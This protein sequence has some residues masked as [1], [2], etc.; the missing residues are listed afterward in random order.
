MY[1]SAVWYRG[2]VF[3]YFHD[4]L[5]K[6]FYVMKH[7]FADSIFFSDTWETGLF[8]MLQFGTWLQRVCDFRSEDILHSELPIGDR[9]LAL[10]P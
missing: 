10:N 2:F 1:F 3:L 4:I 6:Q 8:W 5:I 7:Y 9:L